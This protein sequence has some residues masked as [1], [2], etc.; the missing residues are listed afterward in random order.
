MVCMGDIY[1]GKAMLYALIL[2]GGKGERFWPLSRQVEPKQFLHVA[3]NR[4]LIQNTVSRIKKIII[5]PIILNFECIFNIAQ[6]I[7]VNIV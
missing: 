6:N 2:A 7:I 3:H 4:S 1:G 5:T